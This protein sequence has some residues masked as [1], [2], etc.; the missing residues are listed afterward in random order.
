MVFVECN[1]SLRRNKRNSRTVYKYNK[2]NW[3]DIKSD[4]KNITESLEEHYHTNDIDEL[5][6][7]FKKG[8]L[9][10]VNTGINLGWAIVRLRENNAS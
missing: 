10:S 5:W 1:I 7:I 4:I 9:T 2:A 8:L 6:N 3:T